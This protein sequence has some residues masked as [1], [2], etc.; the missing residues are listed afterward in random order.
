MLVVGFTLVVAVPLCLV[1]SGQSPS[2][3]VELALL[4]V[5]VVLL[6]YFGSEIG[7]PG[8]SAAPATLSFAVRA[9][10]QTTVSDSVACASLNCMYLVPFVLLGQS[11]SAFR[12]L[13]FLRVLLARPRQ[14]AT[15][16]VRCGTRP[17]SRLLSANRQRGTPV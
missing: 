3:L 15:P 6:S 10:W 1:P 13:S 9:G 2:L 5:V 14:V 17:A 12:H 8:T 11:G 4:V 7:R 16:K